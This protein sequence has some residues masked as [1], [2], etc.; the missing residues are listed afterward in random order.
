[1]FHN[2]D[3][4]VVWLICIFWGRAHSPSLCY[5]Y[6]II[7]S[8]IT[9]ALQ[10]PLLLHKQ[11]RWSPASPF[12]L[13]PFQLSATFSKHINGEWWVWIL[14]LSEKYPPKH[15]S[16]QTGLWLLLLSLSSS[17]AAS[18]IHN[19]AFN[20]WAITDESKTNKA[21]DVHLKM[22]DKRVLRSV[23]TSHLSSFFVSSHLF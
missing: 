20:C 16:Q 12:R 9:A 14:Q 11:S 2:S 19:T 7:I 18:A 22:K 6:N 4:K 21:L 3:D 17:R 10:W 23:S 15:L 1:M 8:I 13:L 5:Y